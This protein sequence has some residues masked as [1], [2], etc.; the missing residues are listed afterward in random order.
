MAVPWN[1]GTWAG[2]FVLSNETDLSAFSPYQPSGNNPAD[3]IGYGFMVLGSDVEGCGQRTTWVYAI[4][5]S[6][7]TYY[8]QVAGVNLQAGNYSL[9]VW[10]HA[11]YEGN[12]TSVPGPMTLYLGKQTNLTVPVAPGPYK[13]PRF[14]S[15]EGGT[16]GRLGA[17]EL[18]FVTP[19]ASLPFPFV[20][21]WSL[22]SGYTR[23]GTV[24]LVDDQSG[25]TGLND[26]GP[27][28]TPLFGLAGVTDYALDLMVTSAVPGLPELTSASVGWSGLA[29]DA[30]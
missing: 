17:S 23:G 15:Q 22:T 20:G 25:M 5:S 28:P 30:A 7:G 9:V 18:T 12:P 21:S 2:R 27:N 10:R 26:P 8:T 6:E 14:L 16:S 19:T 13:L 24:C 3:R 29:F 1:K 4:D 11:T